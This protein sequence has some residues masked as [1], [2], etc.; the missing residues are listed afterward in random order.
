[1]K[2][3][4]GILVALMLVVGVYILWMDDSA[5]EQEARNISIQQPAAAAARTENEAAVASTER[6]QGADA[7][8]E[9]D[10]ELDRIAELSGQEFAMALLQHSGDLD[11]S[12]ENMLVMIESGRI[13]V[14]KRIA[15]LGNSQAMTPFLLAVGLS[16]GQLTLDQFHRFLD[17]GVT[18]QNDELSKEM[19]ASLDNP[20]VI[21]AWYETAAF[22]P[23]DHE[24]LLNN[25]LKNG[26]LTLAEI[27]LE[28]K[29]GELDGIKLS[30]D[31]IAG[32]IT[33][34]Q[35][36]APLE[37]QELKDELAAAD[38]KELKM[39]ESFLIPRLQNSVDE[40]EILLQYAELSE[41]QRTQVI[42]ANERY[43]D[44][45]EELKEILSTHSGE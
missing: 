9:E 32:S 36:I 25:S 26:N 18:L 45:L 33:R 19:M 13:D 3:I 11:S 14:N 38:E 35:A 1:M 24:Q 41:E 6:L 17:V 42:A 34:I 12:I 29:K 2:V 44:E 4:V 39:A 22:G 7:A 8:A 23:E 10:P 40:T 43:K 37:L 21:E 30:S 28:D 16:Q 5:S 27:I 20:E 15:E 31:A